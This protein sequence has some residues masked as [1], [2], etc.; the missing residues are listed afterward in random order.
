MAEK[1]VVWYNIYQIYWYADDGICVRFA[2]LHQK[3]G[4][5]DRAA[6]II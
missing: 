4:Y 2:H 6:E 3:R 1:K 5:H